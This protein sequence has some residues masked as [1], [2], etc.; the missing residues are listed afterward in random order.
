M[1]TQPSPV[2]EVTSGVGPE[3]VEV[4]HSEF[5]ELLVL[6]V[7][8]VLVERA[9]AEAGRVE[10]FS[11]AGVEVSLGGPLSHELPHEN[12]PAVDT[13]QRKRKEGKA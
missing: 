1:R 10:D 9:E 8:M 6:S 5:S 4:C 3:A 13:E 11:L 7:V 2:E 12:K